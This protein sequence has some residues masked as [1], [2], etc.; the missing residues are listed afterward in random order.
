MEF[1]KGLQKL[2]HKTLF[3]KVRNIGCKSDDIIYRSYFKLL[4]FTK[5]NIITKDAI[6]LFGIAN[7]VYGWM[8]TMLDNIDKETIEDQNKISNIWEN[9]TLGSL[10]SDFLNEI[11]NITN[12]SIVGGSKLLHFVNPNNYAIFD[13]KVY[14]AI[15]ENKTSQCNTENYIQYMKKLTQLIKENTEMDKLKNEFHKKNEKDNR[16]T[17][18][19][20]I[21]LILWYS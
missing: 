19:R 14:K 7:M 9:I 17:N 12:N 18:F 20:Y 16:I 2:N 21:E 6:S 15:T 5:R 4:E 13:S 10:D 1:Y 3:D 8:P 11:K